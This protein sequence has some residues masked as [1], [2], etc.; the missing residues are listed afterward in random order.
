MGLFYS[1]NQNFAPQTIPGSL[2]GSPED[3]VLRGMLVEIPVPSSGGSFIF[4]SMRP[5]M[6]QLLAAVGKKG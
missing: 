1:Q 2:R 6:L 5:S 3:S 4:I